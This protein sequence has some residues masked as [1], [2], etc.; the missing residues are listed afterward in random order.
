MLGSTALRAPLVRL[1]EEHDDTVV[2][3]QSKPAVEGHRWLLL[4]L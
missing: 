4:G 3:R 1:L 2:G